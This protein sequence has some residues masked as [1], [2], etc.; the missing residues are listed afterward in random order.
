MI[1]MARSHEERF[2]ILL[3]LVNGVE[4]LV[5]VARMSQVRKRELR[6]SHGCV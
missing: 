6:F 4:R 1:R 5:E 2:N 3:L